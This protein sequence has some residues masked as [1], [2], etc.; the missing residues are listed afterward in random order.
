MS[1]DLTT[2]ALSLPEEPRTGPLGRSVK[3]GRATR[4]RLA[5]YLYPDH[6]PA[7]HGPSCE[8]LLMTTRTPRCEAGRLSHALSLPLDAALTLPSDCAMLTTHALVVGGSVRRT[9][10]RFYMANSRFYYENSLPEPGS[11]VNPRVPHRAGSYCRSPHGI[12]QKM[13][14]PWGRTAL[15]RSRLPV[16]T[17]VRTAPP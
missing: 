6:E 13:A 3:L 10:S 16:P 8:L 5:G 9:T 7:R 12:A 17:G 2:Y 1:G 14:G 4:R 11:N 15:V